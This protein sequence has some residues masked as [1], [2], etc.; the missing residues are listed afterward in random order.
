MLECVEPNAAAL[1][2]DN[3]TFRYFLEEAAL[4]RRAQVGASDVVDAAV[5]ALLEGVESTSF[6]L[7]ASLS[8]AEAEIELGDLL[9]AALDELGVDCLSHDDPNNDIL[10]A[11]ALSRSF[12][13]GYLEAQQLTQAIHEMFGHMCHPLIEK[14]SSLDD[15]F[16]TVDLAQNPTRD[17]LVQK[18]HIAATKLQE[19]AD[20]IYSKAQ[21]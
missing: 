15:S 16:D 18:T 17:Q 9:P 19:Q 2:V 6:I 8:R 4:W 1:P 7:I 10:V 14:L 20:E 12:L 5:Q 11:A 13:S 21:G 3:P